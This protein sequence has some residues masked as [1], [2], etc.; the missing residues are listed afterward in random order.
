MPAVMKLE[1]LGGWEQH[2]GKREETLPFRFRRVSVAALMLCVK[3]KLIEVKRMATRKRLRE[4]AI[5]DA[6]PRQAL[7]ARGT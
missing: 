7:S 1:F 3:A 5:N 4:K 2:S 6:C